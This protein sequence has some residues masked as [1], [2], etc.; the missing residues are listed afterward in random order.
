MRYT[1]KDGMKTLVKYVQKD[2]LLHLRCGDFSRN[3]T[4]ERAT[5]LGL[6][7]GTVFPDGTIYAPADKKQFIL[8]E[9]NR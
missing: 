7:D 2:L 5:R 8:S 3:L 6:G 9:L 1:N 4:A